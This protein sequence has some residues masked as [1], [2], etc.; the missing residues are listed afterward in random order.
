M[1]QTNTLDKLKMIIN[2]IIIPANP[3]LTG[4]R[5]YTDEWVDGE[6]QYTVNYYIKDKALTFDFRELR[7]NVRLETENLFEMISP[8]PHEKININFIWE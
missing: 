1:K 8:E 2:K 6:I 5:I 3:E 7:T 4:Y